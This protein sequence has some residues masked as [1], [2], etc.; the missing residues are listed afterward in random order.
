M[1]AGRNLAETASITSYTAGGNN[2]PN[3][4]RDKSTRLEWY[5]DNYTP[6]TVVTNFAVYNLG[7]TN[8]IAAFRLYFELQSPGSLAYPLD[9]EI[10]I[11]DGLGGWQDVVN[12]TGNANQHY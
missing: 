5:S 7:Q 2:A 4:T 12:V 10:Q 3:N 11:P 9:Y 6:N 1:V 8:G